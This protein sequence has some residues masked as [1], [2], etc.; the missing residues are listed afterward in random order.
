VL[1]TVGLTSGIFAIHASLDAAAKGYIVSSPFVGADRHVIRGAAW[2]CDGLAVAAVARGP[3]RAKSNGLEVPQGRG[4]L[5]LPRSVDTT[6]YPGFRGVAAVPRV[7]S[8]A[9]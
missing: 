2:R 5:S 9:D 3:R 4:G 8:P 1:P 7:P 6:Q